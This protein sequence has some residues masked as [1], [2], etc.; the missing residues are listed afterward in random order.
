M[1][2]GGIEEMRRRET[3]EEGG[4]GRDELGDEDAGP[5]R[6]GKR[7]GGGRTEQVRADTK[8]NFNPT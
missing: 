8:G 2:G 7:E 4:E 3:E 5:D 6:R 1:G